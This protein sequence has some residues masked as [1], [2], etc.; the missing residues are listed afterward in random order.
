MGLLKLFSSSHLVVTGELTHTVDRYAD[1]V[2][3]CV[4][5]GGGGLL[6][7]KGPLQLFSSGFLRGIDPHSGSV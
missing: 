4:A 2:M 6:I 1:T 3:V 5:K 7:N